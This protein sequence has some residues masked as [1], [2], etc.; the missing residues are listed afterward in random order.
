MINLSTV[1]NTQLEMR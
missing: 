1:R